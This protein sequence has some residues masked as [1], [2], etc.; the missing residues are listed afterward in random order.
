MSRIA[1]E[2]YYIPHSAEVMFPLI[3]FQCKS[4]QLRKGASSRRAKQFSWAMKQM[5]PVFQWLVHHTE[6]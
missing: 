4:T 2:S 6:N 1:F 3:P 5:K